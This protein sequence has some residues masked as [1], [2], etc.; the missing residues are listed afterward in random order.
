MTIKEALRKYFGHSNFRPGQEEIIKTILAGKNVIAVLPT[1]AGKS[2]CYQIPALVSKNFSMVISPLI[3]LMKDQVDSLNKEKEIAAF[4]NSTIQFSEAEKI[5]QKAASG[6]IKIL[7]VAPEKLENVSFAKRIQSL[8][9]AFVFVDE[10]HCISEWGHSFRPSYRNIK[11][12]S[13]YISVKNISAFTATATPEVVSDIIEQL[14]IKDAKIFV[15]GFERNN[16]NLNVIVTKNKKDKCLELIKKYKTPAIV[17]ASSRKVTEEVAEYLALHRINASYYHAGL[18]SELRKKIQEDFLSDKVPIIVATNAFGM[19]I[20]KKDIKLI[21]HY[22]TPGSIENYYQEI[23]RAGRDGKDANVFLLHDDRDLKI[24]DYFLNS[25]Y[26]NK[27]LIINIYNAICDLGRIAI[28]NVSDKEIPIDIEFISRHCKRE[29]NR[30][31]IL[32]ALKILEAAEYL[33]I[34]SDYE[35]KSEIQ[36]VM[37]K[38]KL[39]EF[40]KNCRQDDLKNFLLT[41]LREFG[42]EIYLRSLKIS[43]SDLIKKY[44]ISESEIDEML[45][46]LDSMG[47]IVYKKSLS[48]DSV[49]LNKPRVDAKKLNLDYKRINEN[50]LIGRKKIDSMVDYVFTN[51][52][53]FKYILSYFGEDVSEYSCGRCDNCNSGSIQSDLTS[54]YLEEIIIETVNQIDNGISQ[55]ELIKILKGLSTND[56]YKK[57]STFGSCRNYESGQLKNTI[58]HLVAAGK[59]IRGEANIRKLFLSENA[60]V[61]L[62]QLFNKS[63]EKD[64]HYEEE[65][66]LF[67]KLREVRKKASEKFLQSSYIIC[68]DELLKKIAQIKPLNKTGLIN[69]QGFNERMFNKIGDELL[70]A[71]NR[72]VNEHKNTTKISGKIPASI[73]ETYDLIKKGFSLKDISSI[74]KLSEEV[75]SMQ[76]ET[77]IEYEN[78]LDISSLF[79]IKFKKMIVEEISKGYANLKDLKDRLPSNISY[80]MIRICVSINNLNRKRVFSSLPDV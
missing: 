19:G 62:E 59:I 17:Y 49:I 66:E 52:C 69:I 51:D 2:I 70:Q 25:S 77:I 21:I 56:L 44:D 80:A 13:E 42:S 63:E 37:E 27:E 11:E 16:L 12:F 4:I 23:G 35:R 40:I 1:G 29:I 71:I 20:D 43:Q 33:K 5:L 10:A 65:L 31:L 46:L 41:M 9:P 58:L 55:S 14:D 53:R 34:A 48:K 74:R 68:S 73:K 22:N 38:S 61:E 75:V 76:I 6:Q 60:R 30:S 28:G 47:I 67:N 79:D 45:T 8:N 78:S 50:Y 39:K 26:P 7:Y 64:Y 36:I 18:A 72:F 3:A 57:L 32:G 24:H 15:R 54:G